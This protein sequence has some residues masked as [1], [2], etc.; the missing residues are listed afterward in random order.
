MIDNI[1]Q[2]IAYIC[3]ECSGISEVRTNIFNFSGNNALVLKCT[4]MNCKPDVGVIKMSGDKMKIS[5]KCAVCTETHTFSISKSAFWTNELITFSCPNSG[6]PIFFAGKEESVIECVNENES[7]FDDPALDPETL[8]EELKLVFDTLDALHNI[9]QDKRMI[10]KCGNRN[11]FPVF[12][13]ETLYIEC[14][15]CHQKFPIKA[16][17]ELLNVLTKQEGDFKL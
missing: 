9:M 6:I 17:Q 10:C 14:E 15:S 4:D 2:F 5:L 16:S 11:L 1:N 8:S 13:D 12:E 7:I 3:C